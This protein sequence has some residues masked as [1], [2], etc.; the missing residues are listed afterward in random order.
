MRTVGQLIKAAVFVYLVALVA[1]GI[2][3]DVPYALKLTTAV[4]AIVAPLVAR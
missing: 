1:G 3:S 4:T 2:T